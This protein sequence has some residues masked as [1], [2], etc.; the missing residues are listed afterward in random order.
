MKILLIIL[1]VLAG[2]YV[3]LPAWQIIVTLT[4][5]V[6]VLHQINNLHTKEGSETGNEKAVY[7]STGNI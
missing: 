2:K 6:W 5:A 1:A 3:D 7:Y 4:A